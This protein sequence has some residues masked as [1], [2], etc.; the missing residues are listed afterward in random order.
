MCV[1]GAYR[2]IGVKRPEVVS[3]RTTV[4]SDELFVAAVTWRP[5][6]ADD[7]ALYEFDAAYTLADAGDGLRVV[8]IAHNETP[9]LMALVGR[10]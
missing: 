7:R 8:A 6:G 2:A 10:D 3:L 9:R 1:L 4:V 5:I